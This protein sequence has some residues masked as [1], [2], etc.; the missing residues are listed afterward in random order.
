MDAAYRA[1][2]AQRE[3]H[4]EE[5]QCPEDGAGHGG[6]GCRVHDEHEARTFSGHVLYGPARRVGHVAEHGEDDEPCDE[7]GARIDDTSQQGVPATRYRPL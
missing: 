3:E 2:Q 7:A 4:H 1:V 6:D 5:D